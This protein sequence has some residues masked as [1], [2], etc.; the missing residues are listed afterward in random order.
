MPNS[1]TFDFQTYD[2]KL[3]RTGL[4]KSVLLR[5]DE[6]EQSGLFPVNTVKGSEEGPTLL[7]LAAVHGDE[8]EGV[9]ALIE[10][11]RNLQAND[12]R[13]TLIMVPVAN[14]SSYY[15][16][17]RT[18]LV[19]GL[20]L[21]RVFPGSLNGTFTERLAFALNHTLIA[22]ADFLLDLHSGG[23]H[24]AM[25]LMVGYYENDSTECGRKSKAAAEAFGIEVIWGHEEV[26][27]GRTVSTATD[28]G[29][30]WLY[31]EGYG[32]R[33]IRD[34]EY[35][36]YYE[37]TLRLLKHMGMLITPENW[38]RDEPLALKYRF[39]GDGDL[40]KAPVAEQDGFFVPAVKLLDKVDK[41]QTIGMIYDWFGD[42]LQVVR[43]HQDG[44]V[45]ML[46]E[47]PY[48]LKGEGLFTIANHQII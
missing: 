15:S 41:G 45:M 34:Y 43:S 3:L 24:Y 27:P 7:V 16:G 11:Y 2:S 28:C 33:R 13:G 31:I 5:F 46:R 40:D 8:Y 38:I 29:I 39:L 10:L 26:A 25:P 35:K 1:E 12:I 21:A 22:K 9:R 17:N 19:D 42:E 23:T 4:K 44:Y 30:P 47:V 36:H 14:V 18:T 32:G 37:G 48:T 20:N 6:S